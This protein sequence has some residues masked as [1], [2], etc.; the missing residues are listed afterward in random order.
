MAGDQVRGFTTEEVIAAY[1][2]AGSVAGAASFLNCARSTVYYHLRKGGGR[3]KPLV[4]GRTEVEQAVVLPLPKRGVQRYILTSAQNNTRLHE[5]TWAN[6]QT[7]AKHY[8]ADIK[9]GTFTYNQNAFGKM[10]VKRGTERARDTELWYDERL[11]PY[12]A[13]GNE[14]LAPGLIW[15][16]RMNTLPTTAN[17]LVGFETY[18][19]RKSGIF[20][21]AKHAMQS[22]ASAKHEA[23]K[24][25]YT[26]GT[27]TQRNYIQKAAGIKAEHHHTYGAVL[28]EVNGEGTWWVRQLQTDHRGR[29]QDLNILAHGDSILAMDHAVEAI[30]WGD[31]HTERIDPVMRKLAWGKGGIVDELKPRYQFVHD[32]IDFGPRNHHNIKDPHFRFR[33]FVAGEDTVLAEMA[34]VAELLQEMERPF[35]KTLVVNGNH[36]NAL[37]RW[38]R[39]A[40]YRTDPPNALFFLECQLAV[41]QAIARCEHDFMILEH[42]LRG[43]NCPPS[44]RFLKEDES[45]ITC[46]D[47][48]GGIENGNHGH[49]GPNGTRGTPRNLSRQGRR[50]NTAHSHTASILDG[51][52]TAGTSSQLDMGYNRGP[53]SWT[54]TFI[55][56]YASGKRTLC[57]VYEGRHRA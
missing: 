18:T 52:Y 41:Y 31:L 4:G 53:S 2:R 14:E 22:I 49:L 13:D 20:P 35:S 30:T 26:T 43:Y 12:I 21:H 42:V 47:A 36:D 40:D 6:L 38:L 39:E 34:Q 23:T 28:V 54:H 33:R 17:P 10:T 15:C 37:T 24:L 5:P 55:V 25:N 8:R 51:M 7:L 56:T 45:F 27:V 9:V 3:S 44:V 32:V 11:I 46:R 50:Q 48:E 1:E 57:T 16:G 29:M 19:G